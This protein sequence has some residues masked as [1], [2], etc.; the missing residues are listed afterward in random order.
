LNTYEQIDINK[1]KIIV[2]NNNKNIF[3]YK[4]PNKT[5]TEISLSNLALGINITI[6]FLL[7]NKALCNLHKGGK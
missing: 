7:E 5:L 6:N 3:F 4:L 2:Y 1:Y